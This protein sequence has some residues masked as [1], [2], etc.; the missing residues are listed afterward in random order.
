MT[1]GVMNRVDFVVIDI[2]G[3]EADFESSET[4]LGKYLRG[5]VCQTYR[6][7]DHYLITCK[8][9]EKHFEDKCLTG[10]IV[11]SL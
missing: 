10:W 1:K 6:L 9:S 5:H 2:K 7:E 4:K 8:S 3:S 11:F